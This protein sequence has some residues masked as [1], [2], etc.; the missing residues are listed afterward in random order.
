MTQEEIEVIKKYFSHPKI[1]ASRFFFIQAMRR[2]AIVKFRKYGMTW[3]EIADTFGR[4]NGSTYTLSKGVSPNDVQEVCDM[5][6]DLWIATNAFP[7]VDFVQ[8]QNASGRKTIK[9]WYQI[10]LID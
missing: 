10:E 2:I 9:T 8:L 5:H 3:Q 6:F 4:T 7:T 1:Q